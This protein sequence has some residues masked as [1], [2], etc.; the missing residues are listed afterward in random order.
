MSIHVL[1]VGH[2]PV[3]KK[4]PNDSEIDA[5]GALV[6]KYAFPKSQVFFVESCEAP[7][8]LVP[9][10]RTITLL[11]GLIDTL[12]LYD[13]GAGGSLLMGNALLFHSSNAAG[14]ARAAELRPFL[15]KGAR[16]RLLGC[17]TARGEGGQ[18]L[19]IRL[20]EVFDGD[21]TI[22]GTIAGITLSQFDEYGFRRKYFEELYLYSSLEARRDAP[23]QKVAPTFDERD[24]ALIAWGEQQRQLQGIA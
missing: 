13:H 12:D 17:D 6:D 4:K 3:D 11:H 14:L 16:L 8:Q 22:Y 19:L 1:V 20:H 18:T 2:R 21:V 7:E 10:L 9:I 5:I 15:A 23:L 24:K